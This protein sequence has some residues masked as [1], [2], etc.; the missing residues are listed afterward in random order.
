MLNPFA[1]TRL[2]TCPKCDELT[3]PRKFPLFVHVDGWGPLALGK[4][5]KYCPRCELIMCHQDYVD[6]EFDPG[7]LRPAGAPPRYLEPTP[8][9]TP[10][11][12]QRLRRDASTG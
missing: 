1:G 5:C 12:R 2:S 10:W 7:G 8:P 4:T 3:Y 6:L 9:D 11:R